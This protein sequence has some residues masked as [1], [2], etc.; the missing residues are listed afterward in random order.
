VKLKKLHLRIGDANGHKGNLLRNCF[1]P[2][3][4]QII[5]VVAQV[6]LGRLSLHCSTVGQLHWSPV[7][8]GVPVL[9]SVNCD[10][11]AWWNVAFLK[12]PDRSQNR[13]SRMGFSRSISSPNVGISPR[14]SCKIPSSQSAEL[15]AAEVKASTPALKVDEY[16]GRKLAKCGN[17]ERPA[18][19]GCVQLP[20]SCTDKV[21]TCVSDDFSKFLTVDIH[22]TVS[23]YTLFGNFLL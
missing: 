15:S 19:L 9:L 22:G 12:S 16:W 5:D 3:P 23:N 4:P 13:R 2:S 7:S 10:E 1:L 11:L 6:E 18:L 17:S 8:I 20:S 21:S 14:S